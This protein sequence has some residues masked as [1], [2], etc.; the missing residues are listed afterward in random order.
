MIT[1]FICDNKD[2]TWNGV[3]SEELRR[4]TKSKLCMGCLLDKQWKNRQNL[5]EVKP[6][7]TQVSL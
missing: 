7:R 5:E 3:T 4:L 6:G 2:C 1:L